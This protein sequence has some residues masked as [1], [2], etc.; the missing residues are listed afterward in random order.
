MRAATTF[1]GLALA[2]TAVGCVSVSTYKTSR[3]LGRGATEVLVAPQVTG[4]GPPGVEKAIMPELALGVRR[5]VGDETDVMLT[6]VVLP[7][8]D[9]VTTWGLELAGKRRLWQSS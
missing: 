6:G 4:S 7:A 8:G 2:V 1:L 3:P 9:L 5:G